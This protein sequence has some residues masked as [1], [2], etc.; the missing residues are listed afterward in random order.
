M[1]KM[2]PHLPI[3]PTLLPRP[4]LFY[5]SY[6]LSV[7]VSYPKILPSLTSQHSI[8]QQVLSTLPL[9][10][11]QICPCSRPTVKPITSHLT[12]ITI[13]TS[14]VYLPRG[15]APLVQ[16]FCFARV[17]VIKTNVIMPLPCSRTFSGLPLSTC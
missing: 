2:K 11:C 17:T 7:T 5:I 14:L 1:S 13:A 3:P 9:K 10:V 12:Q 15:F 4:T 8:P 16:P 6:K